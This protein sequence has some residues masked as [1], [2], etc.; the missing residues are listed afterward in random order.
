MDSS[1][2]TDWD[3]IESRYYGEEDN[4]L[5]SGVASLSSGRGAFRAVA[6]PL[7]GK[8]SE[9]PGTRE[10]KSKANPLA[11]SKRRQI[12][13]DN[14]KRK[15]RSISKKRLKETIAVITGI[16]IVAVMFGSVLFKQ[17][18]ITSLNFQNNDTQK[19]I[20]ALNQ[21]SAQLRECLISGADLELIRSEATERL[22]MMEPGSQQII[23]VVLPE[24][25][26]LITSISYNSIGVSP[27]VLAH[28]K[29]DLA[30]YYAADS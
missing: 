1:A 24:T 11:E 4:T 13:L 2:L 8:E 26:K 9:R 23:S 10:K 22:E 21:E 6:M 5:Y 7:P 15:E 19:R 17:A 18:Q 14:Y 27:E 25:D 12:I 16:A 28:A 30:K 20:N 3:I 29:E